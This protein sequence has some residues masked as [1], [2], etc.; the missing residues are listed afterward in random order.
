MN[1]KLQVTHFQRS[2]TDSA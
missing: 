2:D 1:V